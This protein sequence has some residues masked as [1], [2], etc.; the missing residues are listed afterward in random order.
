MEKKKT[1]GAIQIGHH[2]AVETLTGCWST[3]ADTTSN[4]KVIFCGE[5]KVHWRCICVSPLNVTI[6]ICSLIFSFPFSSF[7]FLSTELFKYIFSYIL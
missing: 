5:V 6:G 2:Q 3:G 1:Q 4:K 7:Y